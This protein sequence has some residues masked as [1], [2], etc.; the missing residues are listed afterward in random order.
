M[1]IRSASAFEEVAR[2]SAIN[3]AETATASIQRI[4]EPPDTDYS[5]FRL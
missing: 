2:A 3:Q 1:A 5:C 4:N